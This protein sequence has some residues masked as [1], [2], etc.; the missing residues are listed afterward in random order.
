VLRARVLSV[1]VR[2]PER[3]DAVKSECGIH[4]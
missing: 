3:A 2:T 1:P 4:A